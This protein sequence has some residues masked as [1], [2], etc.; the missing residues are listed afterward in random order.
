[1]TRELLAAA[2]FELEIDEI[3]EMLEPEGPESFLARKPTD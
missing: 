1:M 2:G 3:A